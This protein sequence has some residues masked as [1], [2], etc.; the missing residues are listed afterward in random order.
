VRYRARNAYGW[1][2]YSA[3]A[4][5]LAAQAPEPPPAAPEI[6]AVSDTDIQ[7]RLALGI[8]S[9]GSPVT[10]L[11]LE[12]N[13][14][15]T[16]NDAFSA[17]SS[18]DPAAMQEAHTLN[19]IDDGL[20][21]GSIYK[22]RY[23]ASNAEVG[24]GP[25]SDVVLV[26]LNSVPPAPPSPA[27]VES[28]CSNTS[29]A[30]SWPSSEPS[31]ALEGNRITGYKLYA[32]REGSNIF[33]LVYDGT[34]FPQV[35]STVIAGLAPGDLYDLRV[36][37]MNFN[38]EGPAS[39]VALRTY[40]CVPPSGLRA[41][42]RVP[43]ESTASTITLSWSEPEATGGCPI[44]GYALYRNDPSQANPAEGL[45]VWVEANSDYDTNIRDKPQ[46]F[47]ATVTNFPG[48]STGLAF[49]FAVEAFNAVGGARGTAASYVLATT[50][51]APPA[52]PQV[53]DE[54]TS[55]T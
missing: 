37:A 3:T 21:H 10:A 31:P 47:R 45:E 9:G 38:G 39:A 20:V 34:G 36:S 16:S 30:V 12:I 54:M 2:P 49:K 5:I 32:A 44:T 35:T 52:A 26:A 17:V 7:V 33:S 24:F 48:G 42:V 41:P 4:A 23:R 6:L 19:I 18:Y 25:Y 27:R 22:L 43:A 28:D 51:S 53:V 55:S 40:S 13:G 14:G 8:G 29:I 15:G 1:G 50:P 11:S 46:L